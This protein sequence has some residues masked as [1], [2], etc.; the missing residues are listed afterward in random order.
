MF[1]R[2]SIIILN[3]NGW[4]DTIEC[5]ESLYRITYPNYDVIVVDNGSKD[6]SVQ[7]IREY[8]EGKI[9]VSSKFFKYNPNNKPIKVFEISE[10]VAKQG[11]FNRPLYEK[12]EIN[13]RMILIKNKDN[14]GFAGGNNVGIKFALSVLNPDYILLL[15]NDTVVDNNFLTEL[16]KVAES[17]KKSGA[18]GPEIY[19]Y[20]DPLRLW[21]PYRTKK[22]KNKITYKNLFGAALLINVIPLMY[23]GLFDENYFLYQEEVD[24]LYR[25]TTIGFNLRYSQNA[26]VFHKE[27]ISKERPYVLYYK[28]RNGYYF[29]KKN[30]LGH[31]KLMK[32][33]GN[34]LMIVA[35]FSLE[36]K[37][38]HASMTINGLIDGING[39]MKYVISP[40]ISQK[41]Q[42]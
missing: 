37:I 7:K 40:P 41:D 26:K 35:K 15:N 33:L 36:G 4:Q 18:V 11:R 42:Q 32:F 22:G 24:L 3:W 2:V 31:L 27:T 14:Y 25:I 8:A 34:F 38:K 10:D 19:Y 28:I 23:A 1:P 9:E 29:L 6:D 12:Y 30:N 17:D 5:L 16:V 21:S 20:T 39:K 13:K